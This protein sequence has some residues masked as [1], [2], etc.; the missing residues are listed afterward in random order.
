MQAAFEE[1]G[2]T[3][4]MHM[5]EI[6]PHPSREQVMLDAMREPNAEIRQK[7]LRG[8]F[9]GYTAV[10]DV[11]SFVFLA[12]FMGMYLDAKIILNGRPSPEAWVVSARDSLSFFFTQRFRLSG[13]LWKTDRLWYA[14]NMEIVNWCKSNIGTDDIFRAKC[15]GEYH[16]YVR[17]EARKRGKEILEFKAEDG[18]EPLCRFLGKDVP[19][20]PFPKLNEKRTFAIIKAIIVARGLLSW[21]ALGFADLSSDLGA[22]GSGCAASG[23]VIM[24]S[25]ARSHLHTHEILDRKAVW[26]F[27]ESWSRDRDFHRLC[28][29]SKALPFRRDGGEL[30]FCILV[31][32][33]ASHLAAV[34][35][36]D[37]T[38][39][40]KVTVYELH[41]DIKEKWSSTFNEEG[42]VPDPT[43]GIWRESEM[44]G[45]VTEDGA[46]VFLACRPK[47]KRVKVYTVTSEGFTPRKPLPSMQD[48]YSWD[49]GALSDDSEYLFYTRSGN[50]FGSSRH[51][52]AVEAFSIRDLARV[53][54]VTF[55]F[56]GRNRVGS[57]RLLGQLD[58]NGPV[59]LGVGTSGGF[60]ESVSEALAILS[61]DGKVNWH[62]SGLRDMASYG[63]HNNCHVSSDGSW[64][65]H[66]DKDDALLMQWDVKNPS[67]KPLASV[68]L[69]G[70]EVGQV[71][72]WMIQ[73]KETSVRD[74]VGERKHFLRYSPGCK[75]ITVVTISDKQVVVNVF[76]TFNLQIVHHETISHLT[77]GGMVPLYAGFSES[78]GLNV[79]GISPTLTFSN[80]NQDPATVGAMA[81]LL[82][83]KE[84]HE[85]VVKIEKYFDGVEAALSSKRIQPGEPLCRFT[86]RPDV[87]DR[88]DPEPF[89]HEHGQIQAMAPVDALRQRLFYDQTFGSTSVAMP[90]IPINHRYMVPHIFSF[91][92]PWD[93]EKRVSIFGVIM[94]NEYHIISIGPSAISPNKD[95]VRALYATDV[96]TGSSLKEAIEVYKHDDTY[97]IHIYLVKGL[98]SS[99]S[100]A[101]MP[102]PVW[103]IASPHF[104]QEDAWYDVFIIHRSAH[105]TVPSDWSHTPNPALMATSG[106]HAYFKPRT[107]GVLDVVDTGHR[108]NSAYSAAKYL[109]WKQ[110]GLRGL[111]K[112]TTNDVFFGGG[113]YADTIGPYLHSI[114]ED[115]TYDDVNPLFPSIFAL[116]CNVDYR[117]RATKHVDAF[118]RRLHQEKQLLL[119]NSQSVS[120]SLP[121]ACRSRPM[122]TLSLMRHMVLFPHRMNDVLMLQVRKGAKSVKVESLQNTKWD[123]AVS[124][125]KE[126]HQVFIRPLVAQFKH[127]YMNTADYQQME[128]NTAKLT[129]PLQGF[130]SFDK[131]LY[132]PSPVRGGDDAFWEFI[133]ATSPQTN[134][135]VFPRWEKQLLLW[136]ERSGSGPSSPFTRL[137]DEILSM[138]DRE[139]KLSFLRVTWFEK[140][141]AWKMKTFGLTIYLTRI[142]LP[143]ILLFAVHLTIGILCTESHEQEERPNAAITTLACIEML[144]SCYILYTKAR[145]VFRVPRMF[146]RSLPNYVDVLALA[147]GISCF[148]M[149]VCGHVPSREFLAFATLLIWVA[150]ILMLR[151]YRPIGMLLLL[152]T[153]TLQG[154]FSYLA[155]LFFI[156]LGFAFVPFLLLRNIDTKDQFRNPFSSFSLTLSQMLYFISSD[157]DALEPF[158]ASNAGVRTLRALYIIV[159]TILF[160]NTL[161]AILNLKIKNADKNSANLYHLQM[162]SLQVEIELGLLSSSERARKDWFPEWFHYSMSETEQRLWKDFLEKHPLK[163]T[164]EN[165]FGE[166]KDHAPSV[167][168]GDQTKSTQ[169]TT[170]TKTTTGSLETSTIPKATSTKDVNSGQTKVAETKGKEPEPAKETP[171]MGIIHNGKLTS[172][173]LSALGPLDDS[174]VPQEDDM[175]Y[176]P[177]TNEEL[178]DELEAQAEQA[179]AKGEQQAGTGEH[180]G[181]TGQQQ[182]ETG[183][184]QT[185]TFSTPPPVTP[186]PP[187]PLEL[188][189]I[190]CQVCGEPGKKCQG[191]QL[192]A[193]CSKDHQKQDWKSHKKLCKGKQK[194]GTS[195]V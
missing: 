42:F 94:K 13:L 154:V 27:T 88:N 183:Q 130:C 39:S 80:P 72:K 97:I 140:L 167:D 6:L 132:M 175:N 137:V 17:E 119:H 111:R 12:D 59:Y 19:T 181:G 148:F 53:K 57:G 155:L 131:K 169:S 43:A 75:I 7:L 81:V 96:R 141:L 49:K 93:P 168:V 125:A 176:R 101:P 112:S 20:S 89:E 159:I 82:P 30:S 116:V 70:V 45:A 195:S 163:W 34:E 62:A 8:L 36:S 24:A 71:R 69:P 54:A 184:Q 121:L 47:G 84:V 142:V 99:Y 1:L 147:L 128:P 32:A 48:S 104:L 15:Y 90:S 189:D 124:I 67:F 157:Y 29:T 117:D 28:F 108:A 193:Y 4:C 87:F 16:D 50:T 179:K 174:S 133:R 46:A 192:V 73:G 64:M 79:V 156:I 52:T 5:A 66:V 21:A 182:A 166:D 95:V 123:K 38:K 177:K 40:L 150:A 85:R 185:S 144:L 18:W 56:G 162:A 180:Q 138:R 126:V 146:F 122:A 2:F 110:Y 98:S 170:K 83:L 44:Q 55:Q 102:S 191:C 134:D 103:T 14:I 3:P 149:I 35:G 37:A 65:F 60:N 41:G 11:P 113:R 190:S 165:S 61:S 109:L 76:Q 91:T 22:I 120:Y 187:E 139:T 25:T 173:L 127:R 194:A 135:E 74:A 106:V 31:S 68:Q 105:V 160:L 10:V 51:A 153:E 114:Y 151:I 158:E 161:I 152:L 188:V 143:I 178:L 58:V 118:F 145:Q 186:R 26:Q 63:S 77:W 78:A 171:S 86:W 100:G 9:Q 92:Y 164:E 172:D 115:K 33:G 136:A 107:F 129:L 23:V